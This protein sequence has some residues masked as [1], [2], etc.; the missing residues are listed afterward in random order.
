MPL[1]LSLC[2]IGFDFVWPFLG[3]LHRIW[4]GV[5]FLGFRLKSAPEKL[6]E[7][8]HDSS[9]ISESWIN[10][11]HDSS[12][13][14]RN[15]LRINSR[16]KRIP[17]YWF[18]STHDSRDF[19]GNWL[20]INSQLKQILRHWFKST[21]VSSEKH[22]IVSRVMIQL[23]VV[24]MSASTRHQKYQ[25]LRQYGRPPGRQRRPEHMSY[26]HI[27]ITSIRN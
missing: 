1:W 17:E 25:I 12:G 22:L 27:Q 21:H 10:S 3:L 15:W 9:S 4:L 23:W 26:S 7:S 11:T 14:P 16:L 6:N 24:P 2:P 8:T 5:T 13:F 20:R 18:R 19:Q